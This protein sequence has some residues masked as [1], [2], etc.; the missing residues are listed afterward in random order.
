MVCKTLK[1]VAFVTVSEYHSERHKK[2]FMLDIM[3]SLYISTATTPKK[4]K[5]KL[6]KSSVIVTNKFNS[7]HKFHFSCLT[8][9]RVSRCPTSDELYTLMLIK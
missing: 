2:R 3:T 9:E 7:A 8:T 5:I 6:H 1:T 4:K